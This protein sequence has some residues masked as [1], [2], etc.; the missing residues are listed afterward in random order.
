MILLV[1]FQSLLLHALLGV[2]V[3]LTLVAEEPKSRQAYGWQCYFFFSFLVFLL[4]V[5][6]AGKEF[7]HFD[8]KGGGGFLTG[9]LQG[10]WVEE[11]YDLAKI[12]LAV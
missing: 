11:A 5:S 7:D 8:A 1:F 9:S 3:K 10:S 12:E 4:E 6:L 2:L